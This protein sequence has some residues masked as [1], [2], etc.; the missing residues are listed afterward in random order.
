MLRTCA[1]R[2]SWA[3][4][5]ALDLQAM[6]RVGDLTYQPCETLHPEP[7]PLPFQ[8]LNREQRPVPRWSSVIVPHHRGGLSTVHSLPLSSMRFHKPECQWHQYFCLAGI[9]VWPPQELSIVVKQQ[10]H[11]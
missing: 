7:V 1:I 5:I 8:A 3:F 4:N 2:F 9:S 6:Y 10:E 11:I